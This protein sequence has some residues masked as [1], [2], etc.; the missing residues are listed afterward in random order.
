MYYI[1][2]LIN[3]FLDFILYNF[4]VPLV[5]IIDK[6][7]RFIFSPIIDLEPFI[8]VLSISICA[9]GISFILS[10]YY[11]DKNFKKLDNRF[12]EKVASLKFA[13]EIDDKDLRQ[14][15]KKGINNKADQIYENILMDKFFNLGITYFLPMFLFAIWLDYSIFPPE[16]GEVSVLNILDFYIP[17]SFWF[18]IFFNLS[19]LIIYLLK[20][21]LY[22]GN[23]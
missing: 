1:E 10:L 9:C 23:V 12:K 20:K 19:L 2:D 5:F 6:I 11:R 18:I 15:L 13:D 7:L 17:V 21:S 4:I 16:N 22:K 8:L 14:T 3:Q